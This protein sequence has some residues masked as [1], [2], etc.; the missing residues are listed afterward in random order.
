MELNLLLLNKRM[1][2][3][4]ADNR[5]YGLCGNTGKLCV[6]VCVCVV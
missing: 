5:V 4:A 3:S 6:C 1:I 2:T